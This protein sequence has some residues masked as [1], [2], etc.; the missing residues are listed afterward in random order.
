MSGVNVELDSL[1]R[2]REMLGKLQLCLNQGYS[3]SQSK[4]KEI[5]QKVDETIRTAKEEL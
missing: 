3:N 1:K 2:I 5:E 4:L